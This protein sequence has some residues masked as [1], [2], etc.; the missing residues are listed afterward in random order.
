MSIAART[1][2]L[3]ELSA[4][5]SEA[6][7]VSAVAKVIVRQGK[8]V[9]VCPRRRFWVLTDGG[10]EFETL[11]AEDYPRHISEAWRRYRADPDLM[12]T[13]A[14]SKR[15]NRCSLPSFAELQKLYPASATI[16]GRRRLHLD[17]RSP[18]A[19]RELGDGCTVLPFH[20]ACALRRRIFGAAPVRGPSTALRRWIG[21]DSTSRRQSARRVAEEA[22]T[23]KDEFLSTV[24]H[25]AAHAAQRHARVGVPPAQRCR[26]DS[27][28]GRR[29][30]R[31][32]RSSTM[33]P[34]RR[35]SSRNCWT[36][37]GLSRGARASRSA[38]ARS[39]RERPRCRRSDDAACRRQGPRGK[40]STPCQ[41]SASSPI[42][43]ASSRCS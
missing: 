1:N 18:S 39:W 33:Q 23:S 31:S 28:R 38:A 25:R 7:T 10:R 37:R 13:A 36:S 40:D 43:A 8:V 9:V 15:G 5:L 21:R 2:R 41:A 19:G 17:G 16:S 34:A 3:Y 14:S 11:Y 22:D 35:I 12:S 20:R 24:S 30:P 42:R 27:T 26:L 6:I 4:G 29:E 32:K